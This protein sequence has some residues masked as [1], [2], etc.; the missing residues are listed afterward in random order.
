MFE[1][2]EK[3]EQE[4]NE[5]RQNILA[6]TQLVEGISKLIEE[7]RKQQALI[8]QVSADY[9]NSVKSI[10]DNAIAN[11]EKLEIETVESIKKE[12]SETKAEI[13]RNDNENNNELKTLVNESMSETAK[14]ISDSNKAYVDE[15]VRTDASLKAVKEAFSDKCNEIINNDNE[16]IKE[17]KTLM[18][19]RLT[20]AANQIV[21]ANKTY[22]DELA[23]TDAS[24]KAM[25][26]EL[27]DKYTEFTKRMDN[28]RVDEMLNTCTE[29]KK[30]LELKTTLVVVGVVLLIILEVAQFFIK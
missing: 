8:Q 4:I 5:F 26:N 11:I 19:D 12:S 23:H 25:Q 10:T 20:E 2:I 14:Q 16:N 6:S 9:Q 24:M 1:D 3:M 22:V 28:A 18:S 7:N 21:D 15:L 29:L 27:T 30:S 17:L 13:I